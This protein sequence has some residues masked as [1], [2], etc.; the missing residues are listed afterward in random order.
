MDQSYG[1]DFVVCSRCGAEFQLHVTHCID[2]GAPTQSGWT[3]AS[4]RRK[5]PV[6][7]ALALPDDQDG[8]V[9][10][11]GQLG[12]AQSFGS[13]L[14][15]HGMPWRLDVPERSIVPEKR[16]PYYVCVAEKDLERARELADE[17]A[18]VDNPAIAAEFTALPS[19]DQ[20]PACGSPALL[21]SPECPSC[22]LVL[23]YEG[24]EEA[25]T[26]LEEGFE[27]T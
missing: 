22:G 7:R 20:C 9:V 1:T 6:Q 23:D 27:Y 3:L 10:R 17:H 18:R 14:E 5:E 15:E 25:T 11:G 16:P 12:W 4:P 8:F 26:P 13:F 2:C 19:V 21:N 24:D